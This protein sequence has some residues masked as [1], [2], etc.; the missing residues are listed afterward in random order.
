[1]FERAAG[2]LEPLVRLVK[3]NSDAEPALSNSLGVRAIPTL[4]LFRKGRELAR[5][6]G[7]MNT[8]ALVSW[9]RQGLQTAA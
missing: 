7:A 6:A 4:L 9:A 2:E 5:T 1:M 8:E 3:L